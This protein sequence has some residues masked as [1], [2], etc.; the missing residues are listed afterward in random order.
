MPKLNT[1]G[2]CHVTHK[3]SD[4]ILPAANNGSEQRAGEKVEPK[5]E[6]NVISTS[7]RSSEWYNTLYMSRCFTNVLIWCESKRILYRLLFIIF[8][9]RKTRN[10]KGFI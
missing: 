4:G 8:R 9:V 3:R 1:Y 10:K 7:G 6:L 2:Q 5:R